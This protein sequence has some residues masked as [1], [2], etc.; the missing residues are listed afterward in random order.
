MTDQHKTGRFAGWFANGPMGRY[1]AR[2]LDAD[3]V[4]DIAPSTWMQWGK[5]YESYYGVGYKPGTVPPDGGRMLVQQPY[6]DWYY[7]T[8]G[9][10]PNADMPKW[11]WMYR[12]R[13][14]VRHGI[15]I[16]VTLSIGR[17]FAVQVLD[18]EDNSQDIEDYANQLINKLGMRDVLQSAV[19]DMLVYGTAYF[20]KVR[21]VTDVQD[22]D[23]VNA[24]DTG[25]GMQARRDSVTGTWDGRA[26]DSPDA[27]PSW[28]AK[29]NSWVEDSKRVDQWLAAK[30][31][32]KGG[33]G[34]VTNTQDDKNKAPLKED[35][36]KGILV[37]LKPLDPLW[38]RVNR[39]A[40][41]NVMGWVQWGLQPI[42]QAITNEKLVVL[43]W[44][45]KSWAQ[46][47]AYGTSILMPVQRHVSML[48]QAEEDMKLWFHQYAKP[49]LVIR[50][51]TPE[52]PY[53]VPAVQNLVQSVAG[54]QPNTDMVLPGDVTAE[55]MKGQTG[56]T[57]SSFK[58]WSTY[59]REKVYETMGIPNVLMNLADQTSRASSDVSLQA[60]VAY[61]EMIQQI[62][63]EQVMK[64]V[65][66]PELMKQFGEKLPRMKI[67]WPDILAEDRNKKVD[68]ITKATGVPYMTINEARAEAGMPP[69]DEPV[70]DQIAVAPA[71][72]TMGLAPGT[73][74]TSEPG[75]APQGQAPP[76]ANIGIPPPSKNPEQSESTRTGPREEM[77]QKQDKTYAKAERKANA[78]IARSRPSWQS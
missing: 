22:F 60:F 43:K 77:Q 23:K 15:D 11:R 36:F 67:V 8:W 42:P 17:G 58:E 9:I 35:Q 76:K 32:P 63:G 18:K 69:M 5:T 4:A 75:V 6:S 52:K 70:Y 55:V 51:G 29:L 72:P 48:I 40:F 41:G 3:T 2:N 34:Q 31:R 1:I 26:L 7:L 78:Q 64:Q 20:E 65:I 74:A 54:R 47:N 19:S 57:T 62:T 44:M 27:T 38:M 49:T 10:D 14:E 21:A 66:E 61:E 13:P 28:Q 53:P 25:T 68:R 12:A 73:E 37:E 30:V 56:E 46:E 59:L 24:P 45:P 71:G 33:M 39:D 50:A 16:M